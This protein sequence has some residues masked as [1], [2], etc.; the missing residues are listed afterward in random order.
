MKARKREEEEKRKERQR[1]AVRE[2]RKR[3]ETELGRAAASRSGVQR[4]SKWAGSTH[5]G[6]PGRP[7]PSG[8][9]KLR[10]N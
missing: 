10:D 5:L 9:L 7:K 6:R 2:V 8:S 3:N 1:E 4:R